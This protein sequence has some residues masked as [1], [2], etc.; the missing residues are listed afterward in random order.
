MLDGASALALAEEA[1]REAGAALLA[2]AADPARGVGTKSSHTDPASDADRAAE[3]LIVRRI[4]DARPGDEIVAEEGSGGGAG[5]TGIRWYVDPLDGTVNFLYGLPQWSVVI[6]CVDA[7]GTLAGVVYDPS[8]DELFRASRGGGAW[9]GGRR[10]RVS[11]PAALDVA[12]VATGFSYLAGERARQARIL[13]AVLPC[14]RDVR[15]LGSAALDLAWVAAGRA[16]AYFESVSKPWDWVAGALLVE[17]AGGVVTELAEATGGDPR[18]VASGARIH[19]PLL[20]LLA[21]AVTGAPPRSASGR[22]DRLGH[23]R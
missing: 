5:R 20:A 3:A 23:T 11:E 17:E 14:V 18:V 10:L 4:R 21:G 7:T 16:D 15:R 1:A 6:A 19:A 2:R 12:L 13:D 22:G 8:R 9:L